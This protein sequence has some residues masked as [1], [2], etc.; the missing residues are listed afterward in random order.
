[1]KALQ[2]GG[3]MVTVYNST[4]MFRDIQATYNMVIDEYL[5]MKKLRSSGQMNTGD[6]EIS[7]QLIQSQQIIGK[8]ISFVENM[9]NNLNSLSP[10][11]RRS[12]QLA[13]AAQ[14]GY[15]RIDIKR[16][17][18]Q[19]VLVDKFIS[20]TIMESLLVNEPV[21]EFKGNNVIAKM[22]RQSVKLADSNFKQDYA[23]SKSFTQRVRERSRSSRPAVHRQTRSNRTGTDYCL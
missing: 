5:N 3:D 22:Q 15:N 11:K 12:R 2:E 16:N 17:Y 6:S 8:S 23:V 20:N 9:L 13:E 10:S 21:I 1:M 14:Q 18:R 4:D 7:A 19:L